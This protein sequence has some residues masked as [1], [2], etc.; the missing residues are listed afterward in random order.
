MRHLKHVVS[1]ILVSMIVSVATPLDAESVVEFS[2]DE[3]PLAGLAVGTCEYVPTDIEKPF[4]L[5][6]GEQGQSTIE[7]KPGELG[8]KG[9]SFTLHGHQG[10]FVSWFG[11]VRHIM[12]IGWPH[13]GRLLIQNT[14]FG[15]W[16]DCHTQTVEINGGGDFAAEVSDLPDDV[17]PLVLV[18]VYG[19][20]REGD[21]G[22][23]VIDADYV[24][25]WHF[26]QFN[27]M[28]FGVDHSNPEWRNRIKLPPDESIYHIGVSPKYY[29]E[30]LGPTAEEWDEIHEFH[31]RETELEFEREGLEPLDPSPNYRPTDWE[32]DYFEDFPE[33][34]RVTV[35]SKPEENPASTFQLKGHLGQRVSWFGI[36]REVTPNAI[37]K[38]GGALLIENKYF[39]GSG[40]EKLQT[41]SIRGGG[42]FVAEVSN[43]SKEL[44]PLMLVRVYG[45]VLREEN[46]VPVVKVKFLR[47]WHI[48][49][50]NF[51]D[52]GEDHTDPRWTKSIHLKPG[53]PIHQDAVSAEYYIDRLS[54]TPEQT[55]KVREHFRWLNERDKVMQDLADV[56]EV[57][58]E[59]KK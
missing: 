54:P 56:P 3:A 44:T 58:V 50:Y 42:S 27:F 14:Y 36:V 13:C 8:E 23:P 48:G 38:R 12:R 6:L 53:E 17:I 45:R 47:G 32:K 18:R 5:R 29:E 15:E 22:R 37:G 35:Q 40:D 19:V 46:G 30:R 16:T 43:F 33:N 41:V 28:D 24:R 51:D 59:T 31:R 9:K 1:L 49:Q 55:Q 4:F 25:V 11:I 39:K 21:E 20:V 57:S 7:T 52:Y 26:F 2:M 34:E 10:Q